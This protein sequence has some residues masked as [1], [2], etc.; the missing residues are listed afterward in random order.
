[1]SWTAILTA[2]VLALITGAAGYLFPQDNSLFIGAIL[3]TSFL[4]VVGI[5]IIM[6]VALLPKKASAALRS[7]FVATVMG[8]IRHLRNWLQFWNTNK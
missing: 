6:A 3:A 4:V 2:A 5:G 1:M 7:T 8:D